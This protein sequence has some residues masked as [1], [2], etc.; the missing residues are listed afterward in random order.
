MRPDESVALRLVEHARAIDPATVIA[1]ADRHAGAFAHRGEDDLPFRILFVALALRRRFDSVVDRVPQQMHE[2]IAELVEDGAVELDL[3]SF[4]PKLHLFAELTRDVADETGEAVEHLP[5][6]G[7]ARLDDFALQI[8]GE[9]RDLDRHVVDHRILP[10][11]ACRHFVQTPA[12][13]DELADQIHQRIQ[14]PQIDADVLAAA[15]HSGRTFTRRNVRLF[16]AT[17]RH[18]VNIA[19]SANRSLDLRGIRGR[20]ELER[21]PSVEIV[22]FE[23]RRGGLDAIHTAQLLRFADDQRGPAALYGGFCADGH[24]DEPT[25]SRRGGK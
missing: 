11:P 1:D 9:T 21:K 22:R 16:S 25:G 12:R 14:A 17:D 13:G 6:G 8:G 23:R 19:D 24:G 5:H 7:H 20:I 10:D 2:W 3:F 18:R 4:D 15:P